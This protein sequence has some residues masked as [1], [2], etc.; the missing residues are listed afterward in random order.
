MTES[1]L[2]LQTID[3][4]YAGGLDTE[5]MPEALGATSSLLGAVG[6]TLEV[7]SKPARR[8]IGFWSAGLPD[9]SRAQYIEHFA[10]LNPR[11][12]LTLRQR[13]GDVAW[14]RQLFDEAEMK[15]DAF[16]SEFLPHL[17][18]RYFVSIVLEQSPDK[19]A[20]VAVQR[21]RKQGH[22]E[23]REINLMRRLRPH[24]QR[25]FDLATRLK[26]VSDRTGLLENAVEWLTDG[27]ALLR[28]DGKIVYA[29]DAL[30]SFAQRGDGI[31]II[32]GLLEL[33]S[34][35]ARRSFD[36]ALGAVARLGNA[37]ADAQATD[38]PV[39]RAGGAPAYVVSMRPLARAKSRTAHSDADV[40]V[41]VRDPL[42]PN[43]PKT[44]I[45]Q[46][47]FKLTNA[48]AHL[49]RALCNGVT[50]RAY[51]IERRVTLNTVYS[52]LK[53]I[54]EKTGCRSV[55]ELI[56]KFGEWNVPLRLS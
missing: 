8:P 26:G 55:P 12:P 6:A 28:A 15:R 18:L 13:A 31:R 5:F 47:L 35:E 3:A 17:G 56:R 37:S 23:K 43:E 41:L 24:Y 49:A 22:V 54:R 52:H 11:I 53:Q 42:S 50:T 33:G 29:N 14:D 4:I 21:T 48:E 20:V 36:A 30:L 16:Y 40:M 45:L 10:S 25:A 2:F 27:V 19:L 44:E 38:F 46:E 34:H 1:E 7:I 39:M 51:A 9:V 32:G